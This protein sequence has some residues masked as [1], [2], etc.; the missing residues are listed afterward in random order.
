VQQL[1]QQYDA[2]AGEEQSALPN[3]ELDSEKLMQELQE[4]L[5]GQR[6]RGEE[7]PK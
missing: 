4:F 2:A 5:R 7:G 6:E 3:E 1:E